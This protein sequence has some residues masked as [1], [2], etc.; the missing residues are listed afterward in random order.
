MAVERLYI[1]DVYIPMTGGLNPSITK[2]I[3]DINEPDKRKANYSKTITLPRSKEL[4]NVF[5]QIFEINLIDGTYN[6]NS[7]A[8]VVYTVDEEIII[9]GY[10]KLSAINITDRDNI[11]YEVVLFGNNADFFATIKEEYLTELDLS[12]YNHT[13]TLELQE[14]SWDT[15]IIINGVL[16]PFELGTG[17]VYPLI[18]YGF[19]LDA[20]NFYSTDMACCIYEREYMRKIIEFA[21]FTYTSAFLDSAYFKAF[22]IPSSPECYQ[23]DVSEIEDREYSANT[24][25]LTSTGTTTSD[26]I[27]NFPTYTAHDGII[28]TNEISDPGGNYDPVTGIFTAVTNGTYNFMALVDVYGNFD[29]ATGAAVKNQT[30][31][32]G[33]LTLRVT[34]IATAIEV[35]VQAKQFNIFK[36]DAAFT[37]G[38]RS[39]ASAPSYPDAD[40]MDAPFVGSPVVED[41]P[42]RL[43]IEYDNI[44]LLA[45]DEVRLTWIARAA[46][47]SGVVTEKFVDNVGT[48]YDGDITVTISVGAFYNKCVNTTLTVGATLKM[49]KVIPQNIKMIDYFMSNCKRFNLYVDIDPDDPKNLIIEPRDDYYTSDVLNIHHL[50]DRSKEI[51]YSPMAALDAKQYR[52]GFKPDGDYWNKHYTDKWQEVYGDRFCDVETEFTNQIKKTEVIFSPTPMVALPGNTRVLPTIYAINDSGEPVTTKHNIRSLYYGGMKPC[53]KPWKHSNVGLFG[54]TY[55]WHFTYP[56]AGHWDDP[57]SPTEDINFG[58]VKEVFYDDNIDPIVITN[59]NLVNKYYGK[60]LR[61]ITDENSKIVEVWAHITPKTFTDWSFDKLYFFDFAYYRLQKIEGYNP[62]KD[63]TTKCIFLLLTAAGDFTPTQHTTTGATGSLPVIQTGGSIQ[64]DED[65]TVRSTFNGNQPNGNNFKNKNVTVK[66]ELNFVAN[67]AKFVD[68]I[69]SSN[70]VFHNAENVF[71]SGDSNV[72]DA[73]AKNVALINTSGVTV[74]DSD[75]TFIDGKR[76]GYWLE[77]TADFTADD[78]VVGYYID[79]TGGDI[80]VTLNSREKISDWIFKRMDNSAYSVTIDPTA[81]G[82]IDGDLTQVLLQYESIRLRWNEDTGE[83]SIIN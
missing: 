31:I 41:P 25:E 21:G 82:T 39:T 55:Y 72:I 44:D 48:Y 75:V 59:N 57:F 33:Y 8:S 10:L 2:N 61:E 80:V 49:S 22:I 35:Q 76:Q 40:Y 7:K 63:N 62:T 71:I 23:L 38:A 37:V 42:D 29:P 17:Y 20:I 6:P 36:H 11:F 19:S 68:I 60:F 27:S 58:L 69:G 34:T 66:G 5:S 70:M 12:E 26:P 53:N 30:N 51:V 47:A 3:T 43:F 77:K 65:L 24:P 74:M 32:Q 13:L 46:T 4:D 64:M 50:I 9:N 81:T 16:E 14:L 15:Q 52:F 28:F 83:Y 1:E 79:A 73:G 18:D 78:S 56:Y 45:G 54:T 67:D